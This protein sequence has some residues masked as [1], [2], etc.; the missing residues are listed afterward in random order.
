MPPGRDGPGRWAKSGDAEPQC[1]CGEG[2]EGSG[3]GSHVP[4]VLPATPEDHIS[5]PHL[6]CAGGCETWL[7]S[8]KWGQKRYKPLSSLLS[9]HLA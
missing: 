5:Q 7:R 4:R 2:V 8:M 3:S 9:K 6:Q 1:E